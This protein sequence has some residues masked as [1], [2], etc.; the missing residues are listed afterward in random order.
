[1]ET[2]H[3]VRQGLEGW[4]QYWTCFHCTKNTVRL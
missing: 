4:F 1:L 3:D 2:F